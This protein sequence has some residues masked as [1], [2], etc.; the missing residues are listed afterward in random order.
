MRTVVIAPIVAAAA[1]VAAAAWSSRE[2][3][4]HD[5]APWLVISSTRAGDEYTIGDGQAYSLRPDGSRLTTL[6]GHESPLNPIDVSPD[7]RL[8]AYGNGNTDA[9]YVSHA[10]GSALRR[11]PASG[12]EL[13]YLTF[14]PDGS[15]VAI[16]RSDA[17]EHPHLVVVDADG[18]NLRKL[19]RAG[20]PDWSPN[21]ELL[22]FHTGRG[23]VVTT[24]RFTSEQGRIPG[25]CGVPEFSP[26]SGS[27][28][29]ETG[30]HCAVAATPLPGRLAALAGERRLLPGNCDGPTWSPDGRWI[31]Y[32]SPGCP[33]CESPKAERAALKDVGV[34]IVRPDGSDRRRVGPADE[35]DGALYS[36][37]PDGSR[38]AIAAGSRLLVASP[39][40]RTKRIGP[41]IASDSYAS[42]LWSADGTRLTIAAHTGIDPAQIWSIRTDGTDLRRLTSSGVNDVIGVVNGAPAHRPAAPLEPSERVLGPRLL[43]TEKPIGRLAADGGSVAYIADSTET[44]CEHVS[45]WTPSRARI[46]RVSYRLPA[47]CDDYE[48]DVSVYELALAGSMVGWSTNLGCGNGGCGVDVHR[49]RL[50]AADPLEVDFDDGEDYG[51]EFLRPF[52]PVGRGR[53]FAIESHVRVAEPGGHVRRCKLPGDQDAEAV[54]GARLALRGEGKEIIVD[55]H[56]QVVSRVALDTKRL[57]TVLLDGSR[58]IAARAGSLEIYD[59]DVGGL[60]EQRLLLPGTVLDGASSGVVVLRH[61]AVVTALRLDDGRAVTFTP[62]RGPVRAAIGGAGLYYSYRTSERE[63]RLALVPR[64]ELERRLAT[65]TSYQPRCIRSAQTFATGPGPA[66]VAA[67][68]LDG[69]GRPDLVT[70]NER[71]RSVSVLQGPAFEARHDYPLG[72]YPTALALS[73]LDRDGRL[74][75]TVT[76]GG[77]GAIAILRNRGDGLLAPPRRYRVGRSPGALAVG[78]LDG[79]GA[80]DLVTANTLDDTVSIFLNRGDGTLRRRHQRAVASPATSLTIADVTGNGSADVVVGYSSGPEFTVLEGAGDGTFPRA[81]SVAIPEDSAAVTVADLDGKGRPDLIL[82]GCTPA[83]MLARTSGGFWKPRELPVGD[84]GCGSRKVSTGDVNGDGRID[85]VTAASSYGLPLR[86]AVFLN[87][88]DGRFEA[89]GGYDAP[90]SND[91]PPTALVQDLNRD[92]R[93][94]LAV[95]M[96]SPS[97]VA[98]LTNTLGVCHVHDFRGQSVAAAARRLGRGGCRIGHVHRVRASRV[99]RGRVVTAVPRFGAFWPNGPE[100][101]LVVS[102]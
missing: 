41:P 20:P 84:E 72:A 52:D 82:E 12:S 25:P 34:W 26:D 23:C 60:L 91:T 13:R 81:R 64:K 58:L 98:V 55:D 43:G 45:V 46:L 75:V 96:F 47:P 10:D 44:D 87:R 95:P 33:Y 89:A 21:G 53:V 56:C 77:L 6:L 92:G 76:L 50:P 1:V 14:S 8:I 49:A 94:E 42:P 67:G 22:A 69:D 37:S 11:L 57:Q 70:G 80:P 74:D 17:D 68:D 19:G 31:A 3:T 30:S 97:G 48:N 59:T 16:V 35:E 86:L 18:R 99:P 71:G 39:T 32:V 63:G 83:V 100:V 40:G 90:A 28:A 5:A 73:D 9:I 88:G 36:W 101:D 4:P 93:A 27:L 29:F 62:C 78:D 79:D 65:G 102:G 2:A 15:T 85:L 54:D 51:N 38:L 7:G 61:G 24:A 66:V